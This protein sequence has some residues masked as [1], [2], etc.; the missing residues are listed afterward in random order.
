MLKNKGTNMF[1]IGFFFA[2]VN[3]MQQVELSVMSFW[4]SP[5]EYSFDKNHILVV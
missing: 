5:L 3:P 2:V 4:C 1:P